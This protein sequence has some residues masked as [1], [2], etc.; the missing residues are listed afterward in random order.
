MRVEPNTRALGRLPFGNPCR[1]RTETVLRRFRVDAA[2][3]GVA[4]KLDVRLL[5][6]QRLAAGDAQLLGDQ[7]DAGDHFGDR[8]FDLDAGVHL[9]K[10]KIC[11]VVVVD[12]LD[13]AGAAVADVARQGR[14]RGANLGADV[15]G[16]A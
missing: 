1:A 14:R 6:R 3:D 9:E 4:G 11:R 12:E 8:V 13:G 16:T 5:E 2:F 15:R 7:I 10:I